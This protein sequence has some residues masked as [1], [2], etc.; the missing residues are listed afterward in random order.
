MCMIFEYACDASRDLPL[1]EIE[2]AGRCRCTRAGRTQFS[3]WRIWRWRESLRCPPARRRSF[4]S[5]VFH[6]H[7]LQLPDAVRTAHVSCEST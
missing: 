1:S 6:S 2:M 7:L 5:L 4:S 3:L